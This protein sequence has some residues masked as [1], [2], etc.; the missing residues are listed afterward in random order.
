MWKYCGIVVILCCWSKFFP[1][2]VALSWQIVCE[3]LFLYHWVYDRSGYKKI[4]AFFVA[5][6][7]SLQSKEQDMYAKIVCVKV[8]IS[9]RVGTLT[10]NF[11][12]MSMSQNVVVLSYETTSNKV[13]YILSLGNVLVFNLE[14]ARFDTHF[15]Q[16]I[17]HFQFYHSTRCSIPWYLIHY[18]CANFLH[19]ICQS[20]GWTICFDIKF[21]CQSP[22][23]INLL[24]SSSCCAD[25]YSVLELLDPILCHSSLNIGLTNPLCF[26]KSSTI[27]VEVCCTI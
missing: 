3:R 23:T 8:C 12:C 15:E 1:Q 16:Q 24:I 9:L 10:Q 7:R 18:V 14:I 5:H 26:G 25:K 21:N 6:L 4:R 2:C 17:Y 22:L 19:P 11:P 20:L 13:K 27:P